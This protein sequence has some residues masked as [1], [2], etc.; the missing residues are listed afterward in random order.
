MEIYI[1]K[2]TWDQDPDNWFGVV[3]T[4]TALRDALIERM[5]KCGPCTMTPQIFN[6][7]ELGRN[8][9]TDGWR[10]SV[11]KSGAVLAIGLAAL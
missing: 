3:Y 6:L 5:R 10:E 7:S 8:P 9:A 1:C 4:H 2:V 11:K